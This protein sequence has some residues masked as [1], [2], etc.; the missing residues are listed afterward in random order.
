MPVKKTTAADADNL[1]RKTEEN[2]QYKKEYIKGNL[3]RLI[4][5][6]S[7]NNRRMAYKI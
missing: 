5:R 6:F 3:D 4:R 7:E 2:G 1:W